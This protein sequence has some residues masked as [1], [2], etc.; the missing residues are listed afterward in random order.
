MNKHHHFIQQAIDLASAN[1]IHGGGP[2]AAL[3]VRDG[4]I[5]ATGVNQVTLNN[6]PTAHAEI[7][8]IRAAC[9]ILADFSLEGCTL[10]S[11]CEPCPMCLAAI[12]WARIS[13]LFFGAGHEDAGR[14][15]F[16]DE[17]IYTELAL[18][19]QERSLQT[20]QLKRQ[21]ALTPFQLWDE[22]ELKTTY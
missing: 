1:I 19:I 3:I 20:N 6:D 16:R 22:S 7:V 4:K 9:A 8:A 21:E 18:P 13:H 11:S 15:G 14:A 12:Y 5:I 2:F 10:Y 17:F